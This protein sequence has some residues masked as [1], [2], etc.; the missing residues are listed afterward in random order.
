[1]T[2]DP[3]LLPVGTRW[4]VQGLHAF[5][6]STCPRRCVKPSDR[7]VPAQHGE[8][9][10]PRAV[11]FK[12][13]PGAA[14]EAML[15]GQLKDAGYILWRDYIAEWAWGIL[16][17]P[18]RAFRADVGFYAQD[19][20]VEIVGGAHAAGRRK[21]KSD[22]ERQGLAATLGLRVLTLTPEQV[23]KGEAIDMIEAAL[24]ATAAQE[25]AQ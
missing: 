13:R 20:C 10:A 16:L 6:G 7:P 25:E 3:A 21:V 5:S 4:C 2:I 11:T 19:L 1:M 14:T 12:P 17:D 22:V 9:V 23:R 24:N 18:P 15:R 8:R